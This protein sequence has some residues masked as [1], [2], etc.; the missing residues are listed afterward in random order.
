M[1]HGFMVSNKSK[2]EDPT[3]K[4]SRIIRRELER[5][6]GP[7]K[8]IRGSV[9][10]IQCPFHQDR[11]P[12]FMINVEPTDRYPIGFGYCM[13]GCGSKTWNQI[14]DKLGLTKLKEG[15]DRPDRI[16]D[17]DTRFDSIRGEILSS[18]GLESHNIGLI[19]NSMGIGLTIPNESSWRGISKKTLTKVGA[20]RG[21]DSIE[22]DEVMIL[23]VIVSEILVGVVKAR[24][25]K[26]RGLLSYVTSQ[27]HWVK[28]SG[29]F[30]L[31]TA[32]KLAL[33]KNLKLVIVEGPR[34]ALKL[35]QFGIPA[36]AILGTTNWGPRKRNLILDS[37]VKGVIL[38]LDSDSAGQKARKLINKDLKSRI[39]TEVFNLTK[40]AEELDLKDLDPATL[41]KEQLRFLKECL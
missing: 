13:G 40:L 30:P 33:K 12:S 9:M 38:A 1:K 5:V 22:G 15:D 11:T 27:G 41:P 21:Y 36:V 24:L 19:L 4:A 20:L 18:T 28:D 23:P 16:R 2:L 14:A 37:G 7:Q 17:S 3:S 29:L 32:V 10:M 25:H 39:K 31:D 34:D 6:G 35:L 8:V 26:V